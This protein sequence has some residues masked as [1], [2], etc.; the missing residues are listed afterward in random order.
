MPVAELTARALRG[1][2]S[3]SA[4]HWLISFKKVPTERSASGQP[5]LE[6]R[7]PYVMQQDLMRCLG[8]SSRTMAA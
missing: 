3:L 1:G 4:H 5:A 8:I 6:Q 2:R 7:S